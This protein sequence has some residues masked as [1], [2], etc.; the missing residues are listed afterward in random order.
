MKTTTMVL[1]ISLLSALVGSLNAQ[2]FQGGEW[3]VH[4]SSVTVASPNGNTTPIPVSGPL[5]DA[6]IRATPLPVSG[7]FF[8]GTQPVSGPLTDAELRA[9]PVPVSGSFSVHG[10]SVS[11]QNY[12]GDSL[13]VNLATVSV[14]GTS[15]NVNCTGGCGSPTQAASVLAVTTNTIA[16]GATHFTLMNHAT[17]G[18]VLKVQKVDIA[19]YADAAVTGVVTSYNM[20]LISAATA[21][22]TAKGQMHAMDSTDS[23]IPTSVTLSTGGNSANPTLSSQRVFGSAAMTSEETTLVAPSVIFD[24]RNLGDKPLVLR[25]GQGFMIRQAI[26]PVAAAGKV[27]IRAFFTKE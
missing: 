20:F 10:S 17:S 19:M 11:V 16:T 18:V 9:T 5:T 21:P 12:S 7:T 1:S 24:Y 25:A 13:R 6:A 15:L 3:F 23:A 22:T 26:S 27:I 8:Q 4:G 2:S 14:T